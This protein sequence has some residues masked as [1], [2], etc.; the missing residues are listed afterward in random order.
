MGNSDICCYAVIQFAGYLIQI[1]PL[2]YLFYV[3]YKQEFLRFSRGRILLLLTLFYVIMS[4]GVALFLGFQ[5]RQRAGDA[6]LTWIAN[7]FFLADILMGTLVYFTSF[8]DRSGGKIFTYS[9]V[10]E[11]GIMLYILNEIGTRFFDMP[12]A[13]YAPYGLAGLMLNALC[14]LLT[15]PLVYWFLKKFNG[16]EM[17]LVNKK[18]LFLITTSSV[19]IIVLTMI[20]LQM[21]VGL[22]EMPG[23]LKKDIYECV[24]LVCLLLANIISYVI[25][26]ACMMLERE[27]EKIESRLTAYEMQY[28]SVREGIEREKHMHHN[29]RHHF[30]TLG[31]L[32]SEEKIDELQEYINNY[33]KDLDEIELRKPSNNPVINS[34]LSYYIQ[35]A[36]EADVHVQCDIQVKNDQFFDIKDMTVLIGNAMENALKAARG[37][38]MGEAY[39]HFMMKQYRQ[40]VLIKI[41]NKVCPGKSVGSQLRDKRG[42]SYGLASIEMIAGKYEGSMEAWQEDDIFIL[43]VVLN[44][45]DMKGKK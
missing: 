26:F 43:R 39:I 8:R 41:E 9:F 3:P 1:L 17:M 34:V 25:Y 28:E 45:V 37:C 20:A 31:V 16:S 12:Y 36:E 33:L 15:F 4:A 30:R 10:I 24:L 40:S 6:A 18:N 19:I 11:Y 22:K 14:T 32:A 38:K 7:I 44:T 13:Q 42:S 29:L 5:V 23:S 2:M 21:E 27:K 35:Q